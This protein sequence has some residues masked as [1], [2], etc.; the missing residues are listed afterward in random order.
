[1]QV[2]NNNENPQPATNHLGTL[3]DVKGRYIVLD[4]ETTGFSALTNHLISISAIEILDGK[5]TGSQ[6]NAYVRTREDKYYSNKYYYIEEY[7]K[8]I[9]EIERHTL[10]SFLRF[11]GDSIIFA[12][13]ANFDFRFIDAALTKWGLNTIP[14]ERYRCTLQIARKYLTDHKEFKLGELCKYF[15]FKCDESDFHE[16][17]YDAFMC[18]RILLKLF[19]LK[20][21][22]TQK[23]FYL[24]ETKNIKDCDKFKINNN[25][26][27]PIEK[28]SKK[29]DLDHTIYLN[30]YQLENEKI[31][32]R[33]KID[34]ENMLIGKMKKL[35]LKNYD[36]CLIEKIIEPSKEKIIIPYYL[37]PPCDIIKNDEVSVELKQMQP[38]SINNKLKEITKNYYIKSLKRENNND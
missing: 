35:T 7:S 29:Q 16:G 10:Q 8:E 4:T 31:K 21:L 24:T 12:H 22:K 6:F 18:G 30:T 14:K 38:Q 2:L 11:V 26:H 20:E 1:M 19:E 17:L 27:K 34:N 13:N 32:F 36:N 15:D 3:P 23:E 9:N 5:I 28:N 25:Q 37:G 33:T